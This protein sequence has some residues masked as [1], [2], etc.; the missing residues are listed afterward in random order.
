MLVRNFRP[1]GS[2]VVGI[3][4]LEYANTDPKVSTLLKLCDAFGVS[5][6]ELLTFREVGGSRKPRTGKGIETR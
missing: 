2:K 1:E 4:K 6:P 5:L 3:D